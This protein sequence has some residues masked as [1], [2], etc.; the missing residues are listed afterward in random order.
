MV[1]AG[2]RVKFGI[3]VWKMLFLL[4]QQYGR[5]WAEHTTPDT[6]CTCMAKGGSR[7][8]GVANL[9]LVV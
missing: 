7:H 3:T 2:I 6:D 5:V 1:M 8:T 9:W 4:A